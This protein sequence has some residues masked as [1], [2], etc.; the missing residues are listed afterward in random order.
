[1]QPDNPELPGLI[2]SYEASFVQLF[3]NIALPREKLIDMFRF[4]FA[5]CSVEGRRAA[6]DALKGFP[7][8]DFN[9]LLL[10]VVNDADPIVCAT[11]MKLIKSRNMKE[12]DQVISQCLKRSEPPIMQ[13][14]YDIVPDYHIE[15][16]LQ[17]VMDL[18]PE[19]AF[20]RGKIVLK[21]DEN[22]EKVL[23]TEIVSVVPVRRIAVITAISYMGL[24]REFQDYLCKMVHEDAE[25]NIRAAACTA[26]G[27]KAR[28]AARRDS[29]R[30]AAAGGQLPGYG[31]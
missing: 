10:E 15:S 30:N 7:G 25:T 18:S 17:K 8:D 1:M 6:A 5:H 27:G 3:T 16:Y 22:T 19:E 14:V 23:T 20:S 11:V 28:G 2:E 4:T 24:G 9:A 12:V 26:L 13:A 31:R 21:V 29:R